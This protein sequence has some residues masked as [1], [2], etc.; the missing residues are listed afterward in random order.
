MKTNNLNIFLSNA[1]LVV[2]LILL[3]TLT[4]NTYYSLQ[5]N[6]EEQNRLT[7]EQ[8]STE[9]KLKKYKEIKATLEKEENSE[10]SKYNISFNEGDFIKYFHDISV[11][12]GS[13]IR[14]TNTFLDEGTVWANGLKKA[15][16]SMK[17]RANNID[18]LMNFIEK[19]NS[20]EK[21]KM[22]TLSL[23]LPK[24]AISGAFE[25]ELPVNVIYN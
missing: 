9:N 23:N 6:L 17:L 2:S 24:K 3:V 13:G 14:I 1:L 15:R 11:K 20:S 8:L 22:M 19:I 7:V 10:V 21:Y 12:E 16:V 18:S 5:N 4:K 25:V